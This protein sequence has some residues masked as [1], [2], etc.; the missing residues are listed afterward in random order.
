MFENEV[1][2]RLAKFVVVQLY[3]QGLL[4]RVEVKRVI[5]ELMK[6]YNPEFKSVEVLDEKLGDGIYV[7]K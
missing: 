6:W 3:H 5:K 2:Y 4:T 7:G 1:N